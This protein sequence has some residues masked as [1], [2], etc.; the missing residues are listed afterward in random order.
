MFNWSQCKVDLSN[1]DNGKLCL[2][3]HGYFTWDLGQFKNKVYFWHVKFYQGLST[4]AQGTV[5]VVK[6]KFPTKKLYHKIPIQEKDGLNVFL[7]EMKIAFEFVR[8]IS[9]L[10]TTKN[11]KKT[12]KFHIPMAQGESW[13][14][15]DN[16]FDIRGTWLKQNPTVI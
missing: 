11:N 4:W 1:T 3:S 10:I 7:S 13:A 5:Q 15:M 2:Y 9:V 16:D 8:I 14:D 6:L 12:H